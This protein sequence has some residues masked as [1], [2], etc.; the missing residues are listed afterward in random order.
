MAFDVPDHFHKSFTGNVELLLQ[1][2]TGILGDAV[3]VNNYTGE[4]AQVIKQFGEVEFEE[5]STRHS[6]TTFSSIEHKQRWVFPTDF[7]LALPVDKEDELRTLNDIKSPYAMAMMAGWNR[8]IDETIAN[9][10]FSSSQTGTNGGTATA[11]DSSDAV[12]VQVGAGANTGLN[13]PKLI[14]AKRL[15]VQNEVDL[16]AEM[17]C[18]AITDLQLSE[19]LKSTEIASAE[20]N[21]VKA[22]VN[23]NVDMFMGFQ[24]KIYQRWASNANSLESTHRMIPVWVKS[25]MHLGVWNGLESRI[26]ERADKEY[27]TQVFMRGTI[28]ATRT[29]EGKVIK[30]LCAV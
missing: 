13:V 3:T 6:D 14:E 4:A 24:F 1:Q 26:D 15:L 19:L 25:G 28:G 20:Y 17:P 9:A 11:F 5:K 22:L 8:K 10:L 12:G 29:Q 30:I 7:S 21:E 18:I 23:G 2:T 16:N 27:L